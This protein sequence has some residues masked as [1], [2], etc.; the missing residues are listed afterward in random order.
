MP[1]PRTPNMIFLFASILPGCVCMRVNKAVNILHH[2]LKGCPYLYVCDTEDS[3]SERTRVCAVRF[4]VPS[5]AGRQQS[6]KIRLNGQKFPSYDRDFS[7][8]RRVLGLPRLFLFS[9]SRPPPAQTHHSPLHTLNTPR[10][11]SK[12]EHGCTSP[13]PVAQNVPS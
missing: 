7:K 3:C 5:V 2:A 13:L 8:V 10:P 12:S 1:Y 11:Y 6:R 9:L 4:P